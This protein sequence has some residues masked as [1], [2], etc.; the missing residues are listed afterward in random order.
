MLTVTDDHS[1]FPY[2]FYNIILPFLHTRTIYHRIVSFIPT[3]IHISDVFFPTSGHRG[4][5]GRSLYLCNKSALP[6][7]VGIE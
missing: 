3:A 1:L 4:I 6:L 2:Y 5:L 7:V